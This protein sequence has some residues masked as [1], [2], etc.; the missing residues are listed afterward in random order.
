M[1]PEV[2]ARWLAY[3]DSDLAVARGADR[4]GVLTETLCFHAQQA[5][6]KAIKAVLVAG[7]AEPHERTIS[8]CCLLLSP[9]TCRSDSTA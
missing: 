5:A 1:P 3:A 6:E 7:G 4:P 2:A 9:G 8:R